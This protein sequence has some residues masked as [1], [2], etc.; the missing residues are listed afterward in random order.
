MA[1][2]EI[3]DLTSGGAA[4]SGDHVHV[5]RSSNSRDATL[6]DAAGKNV[7]TT[8]G[9][10][11]AGDDSRL[12]DLA[13]AATLRTG[14]D[15]TS[16]LG[17]ANLVSAVN[18][19]S[20]SDAATITVNFANILGAAKVTIAGNRSLGAPSNGK[21]GFSFL[22]QVK[23]SGA[24]RTL[25]LNAAYQLEANAEVGPYSITTSETLVIV[26]YFDGTTPNVTGILR[27]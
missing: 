25:T 12:R 5:V 18:M 17:V 20:L 9:T 24:T 22:I 2:K 8:S 4:A 1:D 3:G 27:F 16:A 15:T 11:A 6:G 21:D 7:G 23:A 10:V 19:A 14:T 13:S 26:G